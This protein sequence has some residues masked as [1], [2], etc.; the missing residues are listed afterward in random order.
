VQYAPVALGAG[1]PLLSRRV[2]LRLE[3]LAQNREF[4]CGRWSVVRRPAPSA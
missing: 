2:E 1:A 4:A 3:E